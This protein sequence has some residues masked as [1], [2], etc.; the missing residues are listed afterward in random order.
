M[1]FNVPYLFGSNLIE[2]A[3]IDLSTSGSNIT[4]GLTGTIGVANGGSGQTSYTNGQLLIG[5]STGNTLTKA[6]L[7]AGDNITITNGGG[8][9]EISAASSPGISPNPFISSDFRGGF[10]SN[11]TSYVL[12]SGYWNRR[13]GG[14]TSSTYTNSGYNTAFTGSS[15]PTYMNFYKQTLFNISEGTIRFRAS[16]KIPN[17]AGSST[18]RWDLGL[19][20]D[21]GGEGGTGNNYVCFVY[22]HSSDK[23]LCRTSNAGSVTS[24]TTSVLGRATSQ[25]S[26]LEFVYE[27]GSCKFYI[28]GSLVA[29]HTT[30]LPTADMMAR[31]SMY[32]THATAVSSCL[33]Y[34]RVVQ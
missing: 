5:N 29:T 12:E 27:S 20:D 34:V 13:S 23:I 3:N 30:N 31:F 6:T 32:R 10:D 9:I 18:E 25:I 24:T 22:T 4:I 15:N 7:T 2:G 16:Y 11:G 21:G 14:T 8:S 33:H 17:F 1:S 28:D 19:S 26:R